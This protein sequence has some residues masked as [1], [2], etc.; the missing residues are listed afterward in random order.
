MDT[1]QEIIEKCKTVAVV[2]L[3]P[4]PS[5]DSYAVAQYLQSQGYRIIPVNPRIEEVL[6]EKSY[7]DLKSIPEPVDVVD[8]FRRPEEALPLVEQ[9][10]EIGARAVWMQKGV[11]NQEAAAL[12]R[13][14]GLMVVM[15]MCLECEVRKWK[16][17]DKD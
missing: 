15:D 3:S 4:Q 14:A 9:A 12:A 17:S 5:R 16:Q 10:V 8:V 2:G 7:P 13:A 6:G 11:V 1:V